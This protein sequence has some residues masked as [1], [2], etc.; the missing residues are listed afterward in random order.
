MK[1]SYWLPESACAP[2]DA[3]S[4]PEFCWKRACIL[5]CSRAGLVAFQWSGSSLA[6]L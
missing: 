1:R 3:P 6:L 5:A 4:P 2:L